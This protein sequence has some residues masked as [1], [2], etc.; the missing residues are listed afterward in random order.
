[1]W[2]NRLVHMSLRVVFLVNPVTRT[3]LQCEHFAL[4]LCV[5]I[6]YRSSTVQI[7]IRSRVGDFFN[8]SVCLNLVSYSYFLSVK[9]VVVKPE[10]PPKLCKTDEVGEL[11]V[12]SG[13]VGS[14]YFGLVGKT[15]H[16]FKV[17]KVDTHT[18]YIMYT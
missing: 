4:S 18:V 10:G 13:T 5:H 9:I 15:N 6:A 11:C 3:P 8:R 7:V 14:A 12:A 17:G 2:V 16:T 1:M